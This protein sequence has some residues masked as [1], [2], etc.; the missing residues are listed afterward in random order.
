MSKILLLRE[1]HLI[2]S[3]LLRPKALSDLDSVWVYTEKIW[4][5]EQAVKYLRELDR[6]FSELGDKPFARLIC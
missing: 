1:K 2:R 3:Y 5:E 6:A 4:G